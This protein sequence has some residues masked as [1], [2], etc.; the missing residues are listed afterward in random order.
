MTRAT[1]L[2]GRVRAR[3]RRQ[4]PPLTQAERDGLADRLKRSM[5]VIRHETREVCVNLDTFFELKQ[6][7]EGVVERVMPND[8]LYKDEDINPP[9]GI[10]EELKATYRHN[11]TFYTRLLTK[12]SPISTTNLAENSCSSLVWSPRRAYA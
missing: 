4:T 11:S 8:M 7:I 2:H 5:I 12:P 3:I 6:I 1:R 9:A 10:I